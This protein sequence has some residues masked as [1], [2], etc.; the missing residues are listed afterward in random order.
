MLATRQPSTDACQD[1]PTFLLVV[2]RCVLAMLMLQ[3]PLRMRSF[4]RSLVRHKICRRPGLDPGLGFFLTTVEKSKALARVKPGQ[5]TV[6]VG[7]A[8]ILDGR[9]SNYHFENRRYRCDMQASLATLIFLS[10]ATTSCAKVDRN[11]LVPTRTGDIIG[12]ATMSDDRSILLILVSVGCDKSIAHG[13]RSY[14]PQDPSYA[15]VIAHIGEIKPGQT[16]PVSAW[17]TESCVSRQ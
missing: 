3:E 1:S 6:G 15:A 7:V 2:S 4:E 10:V 5:T 17:P 14:S 16:K 8:N 13:N 11:D 12:T 9:R